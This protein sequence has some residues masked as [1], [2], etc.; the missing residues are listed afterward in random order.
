MGPFLP[1][2]YAVISEATSEQHTEYC[3]NL[4]LADLTL[5]ISKEDGVIVEWLRECQK[6]LEAAAAN[7]SPE[8]QT[9][10]ARSE[11]NTSPKGFFKLSYLFVKILKV[12]PKPE[13]QPSSRPG[14]TF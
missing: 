14:C 10:Y 5:S 12:N 8:A 1:V 3:R 11:A 4:L 6:M 7:I 2:R 9:A 13:A